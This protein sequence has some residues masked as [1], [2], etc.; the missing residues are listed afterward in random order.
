[1]GLINSVFNPYLDIFVFMFIDDILSYLMNQEDH[2]CHLRIVLQTLKVKKLYA[3]FSKCEF[4]LESM[5]LLGHTT[6]CYGITVDT[7]NIEAVQ[8]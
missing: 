4:F 6:F 7:Q 8:S 5:E 2:A 3:K 1:M